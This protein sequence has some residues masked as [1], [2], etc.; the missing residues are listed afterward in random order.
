MNIATLREKLHQYIENADEV[1]LASLYEVAGQTDEV[2]RRYDEATIAAWHER[3]MKRI[4]G[5]G[6][7]YSAEASMKLIRS[8][9]K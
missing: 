2:V 5:Q 9:K 4:N 6:A 8:G 1:H 3:R 7:S